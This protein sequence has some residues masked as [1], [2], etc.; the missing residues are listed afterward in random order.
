[1]KY[2]AP[3]TKSDWAILTAIEGGFRADEAGNI[4]SPSGTMLSNNSP[5]LSGHLSISLKDPDNRCK[6]VLAHRFVACYFWGVNALLAECVRHL[7]DV[8]NDNKITN[9]AAGTFKE[10]KAD[11]PRSKLSAIGKA[12][13]PGL[14][15]RSR[16]L[17]D[18][19][20]Q[21]MRQIRETTGLAY[22]KIA[23]S[24]GVSTMAAYRAVTR[25]SWSNVE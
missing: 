19:Q 12:A 18:K 4:F 10:N 8:P 20:I 24:F 5:K 13:A 1:M 3:F 7:N 11:I 6:P 15:L 14:I 23:M 25:Q 2:Y 9:L 16:K 21:Q 17:T 22:N